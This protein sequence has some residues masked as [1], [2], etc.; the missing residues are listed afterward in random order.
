LE[1]T[2]A[3]ICVGRALAPWL[4]HGE[5]RR[6]VRLAGAGEKVE[7]ADCNDV[8]HAILGREDSA[9][10]SATISV[11]CSEVPSGSWVLRKTVTH[12]SGHPVILVDSITKI[13]PGDVG[14]IIVSASHGGAS[15]GEF[16][17]A[18][19]LTAALFNDAGIGKDQAGVAG[20]AMLD[21]RGVPSCAV[22]HESGRIGD[23]A[24]MWEHGII[25][26]V[27]DA[28]AKKGA[29]TGMTVQ[30]AVRTLAG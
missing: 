19:A 10:W 8:L 3:T 9:P 30:E 21:T 4:Q 27:N 2:A 14:A 25:S 7:A 13:E 1:R 24:D 23:A 17:L 12:E 26:R 15:S 18:V 16:A 6:R 20:L 22:S 11:R 29:R 28:A 5:R